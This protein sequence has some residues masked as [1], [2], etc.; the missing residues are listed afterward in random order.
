VKITNRRPNMRTAQTRLT[1]AGEELNKH[2]GAVYRVTPREQMRRFLILGTEV[3]GTCF[4]NEQE[5]VAKNVGSVFDFC[6]KDPEAAVEEIVAVATGGRA[7]KMTPSLVALAIAASV[8]ESAA[9]A[10]VNV[11]KVCKTGSHFL[12][13]VAAVDTLRGWGPALRSAVGNWYVSQGISSAIFQTLKYRDRKGW[14]HRDVLRKSHPRSTP[15]GEYSVLFDYLAHGNLGTMDWSGP[16]N[17][18]LAYERLKR[19][20]LTPAGAVKLIHEHRLSHEMVPSEYQRHPE[21]LEA[22]MGYM[23]IGATVRQLGRYGAK[24]L[25]EGHLAQVVLERLA[26][27]TA[28]K[29]SRIHPI[30]VLSALRVYGQGHGERGDLAWT[31]NRQILAQLEKT[32]YMAFDNVE[33]IGKEVVVGIDTSS[34]METGV[35]AGVPGL[36]PREAA[37]V[38]AMVIGRQEPNAH[39]VAFNGG[40]RYNVLNF[41][42]GMTLE[43]AVNEASRGSGGST[44][45]GLPVKAAMRERWDKVAGF[46]AITDNET[47]SGIGKVPELVREYRAEYVWD[48]RFV[49]VATLA[50]PHTVCDPYDKYMMD[51]VGFDTAAPTLIHDF[52]SGRV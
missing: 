18:I 10:L 25:L 42:R 46:I 2:G 14:T 50:T 6:R 3:G 36:T 31:P 17:Q 51:V 16:W 1:V 47:W 34:S 39:F 8:P 48:A 9:L 27:E 29:K 38:M 35:V 40:G 4:F 30:G 5:L 28:V 12:E 26:N 33:P 11:G 37:S 22:L 21:V 41:I 43:Q 19:E 13:F 20:P 49:S 44:D 24:G 23:P 15:G 32:F 52:I 45:I 7:P